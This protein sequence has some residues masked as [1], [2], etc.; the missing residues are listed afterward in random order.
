MT[1][2]SPEPG[3]E[4]YAPD[5]ADKPR[6]FALFLMEHAKGRSHDEL[7][8]ALRALVLA[9]AETGKPGKLTYTVTIRPQAKV[10]G[11]VLIADAI[12]VALPELDRAESIFFTT[13]SGDLSRTD[14][15]QASLFGDLR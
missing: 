8:M 15:H 5:A 14:P 7:S 13:E 2:P 3:P 6:D 10:E 1:D 12:K 4:S 9:V 11:A